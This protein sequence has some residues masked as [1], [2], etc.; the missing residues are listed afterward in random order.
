M[1]GKHK[2]FHRGAATRIVMVTEPVERCRVMRIQPPSGDQP[3]HLTF[4]PGRIIVLQCPP[5]VDHRRVRI[6][7][8]SRPAISHVGDHVRTAAE[9]VDEPV[10][11]AGKQ[12][13]Q[14]A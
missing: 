5:D 3:I 2:Q 12:G 14:P 8:V 9:Q 4:Q 13:E 10:D 1:D 11:M 7:R 6:I